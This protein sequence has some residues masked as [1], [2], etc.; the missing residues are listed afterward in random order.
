M[1]S[2]LR[3]YRIPIA[4]TAAMVIALA[5]WSWQAWEGFKDHVLE[6]ERRRA[7]AVSTMLTGVV[8]ALEQ[9]GHLTRG[10][11]ERILESIIRDY[12]YEFIVLEQGGA[13]ILEVGKIP[14]TLRL[15]VEETNSLKE[16][17]FLYSRK[18]QLRGSE[19]RPAGARGVPDETPGLGISGQKQ[20]MIIGGDIREHGV[21]KVLTHMVIP[22]VSAVLLLCASITAWVMAIR[23]RILAEQLKAER[24]RSAHLEDLG[25]AAAGLAHETKNPLGVISGIAQQIARTPEVPEQSRMLIETIIDEVDK[26]ASRLGHFMTF[27]KHREI[28]AVALNIQEVVSRI[29]EVLQAEFDASGVSLLVSCPAAII[30]ADEE[31]LGQVLVN[32]LLNSLQA[33]PEGSAINVGMQF[34]GARA[35]LVIKDQGRG[36][37]PELLQNI[38]KPYVT[39]NPDGHGLGLAIVKRFV[40]DH[41][42]TITADSQ[43]GEGTTICI[44]G[45]IPVK[46]IRGQP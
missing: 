27:A 22:L 17:Y 23:S 35:S 5:F 21:P 8:S 19:E 15:P 42:W 36:I 44:S 10:E 3:T 41:G 11:I 30:I 14:A 40:E 26:S 28:K 9:N 43:P 31:M 12:P 20:L 37:P 18:V 24:A 6:N 38:F 4:V 13:R 33:S 7:V 25:L 46:K 32:L 1:K 39:G 29:A 45:I 16:G 34:Q 2:V